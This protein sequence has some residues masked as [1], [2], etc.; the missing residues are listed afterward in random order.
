M[1]DATLQ[2]NVAQA[3]KVPVHEVVPPID[4]NPKN[5]GLEGFMEN[6]A[7]YNPLNPATTRTGQSRG[8]LGNLIN[9]LIKKHPDGQIKEAK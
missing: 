6:I 2:Q 7:V 3:L 9:R 4:Q 1:H 5:E 8:W